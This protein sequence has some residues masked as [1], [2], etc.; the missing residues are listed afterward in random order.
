MRK[1]LFLDIDGVLNS[2]RS[3]IAYN[4]Y[5]YITRSHDKFDD[6]AV[7]LIRNLCAQYGYEIVLSSTW[8][9]D[10]NW[11]KL[12]D[13]LKLPII[14][15]TPYLLSEDRGKEI[16]MWLRLHPGVKTFVIIDDDSDMLEEQKSRFIQ[17]CNREGFRLSDYDKMKKLMEIL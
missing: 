1:V 10:N 14:D 16:D 2:V 3:A 6:I 17:T 11:F 12:K 5:P 13:I 4:G 9:L 15:K 7:T 8:R